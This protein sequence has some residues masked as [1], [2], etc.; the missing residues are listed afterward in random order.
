MD[1]FDETGICKQLQI[2]LCFGTA[3]L[4]KFFIKK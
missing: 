2:R 4:M 3:F 1:E